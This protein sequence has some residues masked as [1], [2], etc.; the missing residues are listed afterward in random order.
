MG[1]LDRWMAIWHEAIGK[2][3]PRFYC[4]MLCAASGVPPNSPDEHEGRRFG[5]MDDADQMTIYAAPPYGRSTVAAFDGVTRY[6]ASVFGPH[7]HT[8]RPATAVKMMKGNS[9]S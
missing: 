6:C 8:T 1:A 5:R 9:G 2:D 7:R 3:K 4:R